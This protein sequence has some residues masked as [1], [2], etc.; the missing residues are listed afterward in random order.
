[1][2][3]EDGT[4][5]LMRRAVALTARQARLA[6]LTSDAPRKSLEEELTMA[7]AGPS[8]LHREAGA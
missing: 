6:L 7:A 4:L 3:G 8:A 1:M 2:A 5:G